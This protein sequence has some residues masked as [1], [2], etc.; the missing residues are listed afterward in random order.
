MTPY[1]DVGIVDP[2]SAI[3]I[4]SLAD[5]GYT[6]DVSI[7][8]QFTLPG[9]TGADIVAPRRKIAYGE[10]ILRG[11]IVVVDRWGRIVRVIPEPRR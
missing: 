6:V 11:P 7:A 9:T 10:D 2:L 4:Q 5:L 8:E 3:T 1:Q